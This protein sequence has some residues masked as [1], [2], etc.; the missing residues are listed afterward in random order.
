FDDT[1]PVKEDT[2][3]VDAIRRDIHWLGFDWG[4][5]EFY[6]SDYF[7]KIYAFA[8]ELIRRGKA[9]V[10]SLSADEI[11][12][13]RGTLT[14]PGKN[15]PFRDRPIDENLRM[16]EAM[17][18]GEYAD[19]THVLRAKIDMAHPNMNLRD[20]TLYRIRRAHHHRTGDK[21]CIYPMYD[22][23]HSLSDAI[24]GV[25]HSLCSLEFE[26]HRP[27]Y[28]WCLEALDWPEPRPHQYEF[29]RLKLTRTLMSKRYLLRL[30]NEGLVSGWD[31]PRMPTLSAYRRRGVPPEA[32][33]NFCDRIGV[34]KSNSEVDIAMLEFC[35]REALNANSQRRMA[36]LDPL[37]L[38]ISNYPEDQFEEFEADNNP[39]NPSAGTRQ[40]AFGRELYIERGDFMEDPPK[41]FF[42]LAPGQ[43]VRLKHAYYVTCQEVIKDAAGEI[44]E[45]RC[46]YDP[47]SRGGGTPDGRKVKG[48][49]HWVSAAQAVE[50]EVRI[51]D[52]LMNEGVDTE[53]PFEQQINL[54]ALKLQRAMLEPA[55]AKASVGERFQFLRQGY[56]CMDPD[57]TPEKPVFNRIVGLVDSWAKLQKK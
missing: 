26:D 38:V 39:E 6:A 52:F 10:D 18:A 19:G 54:D 50:A 20:P 36:V 48:T 46:T 24:E 56:Y 17:R 21:W 43:E 1:N 12:T 37:K 51:Y 34:A 30:V 25:S 8:L 53:Q 40:I 22:Y 27:L 15:S 57:S 11:K 23:A 13:Y 44:V 5:H 3:Y 41:K 33:R 35:I 4:E 55:L 31:D 7:E 42:R 28:D 14:E 45:L 9:Y 32:I 47:E 16:F 2:E 49:L 29:A